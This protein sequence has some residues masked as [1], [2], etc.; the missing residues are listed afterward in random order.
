MFCYT[1]DTLVRTLISS[2]SEVII[3]LTEKNL[4]KY[5][6]FQLENSINRR[7]IFFFGH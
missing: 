5:D 2:S 1:I 3:M 4:L 6:L 7:I